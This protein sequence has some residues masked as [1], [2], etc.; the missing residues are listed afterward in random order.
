MNSGAA[1]DDEE[2]RAFSSES[3][4]Y[5]LHIVGRGV[6]KLI[7]GIQGLRNLG[8]EGL[9]D[10]LPKIAVVGDQSTGKS[11]LIEGIRYLIQNPCLLCKLLN[12]FQ[13]YQ[14]AEESGML[15]SSMSSYRLLRLLTKCSAWQCPLEI[16][17]ADNTD[18]SQP[19]VC[20][21]SLFK[22]Y[23]YEGSQAKEFADVSPTAGASAKDV[24]V[25]SGATK[26]RPLGPWVEQH[27][28]NF[29]FATV[30]TKDEVQDV[31]YWAQL[32]ILNPGMPFE[33]YMPGRNA[34]TTANMQVKFSP[35][36]VRL[37]VGAA[38][39]KLFLLKS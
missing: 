7:K 23:M 1:S 12:F 11:S 17:M 5:G 18:T 37:D 35:N 4:D 33:L 25:R 8:V 30:Y 10:P 13:W 6:R 2:A 39:P 38:M 19:W 24:T 9:V 34:N 20:E 36:V 28:E 26:K 21:V 29:A 14:S 16:N 22:R 3:T 27:P 32:A 31:L 15:H